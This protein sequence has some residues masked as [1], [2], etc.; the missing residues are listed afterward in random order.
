MSEKTR[1]MQLALA[2]CV[3]AAFATKDALGGDEERFDSPWNV[4]PERFNLRALTGGGAFGAALT[5]ATLVA[6]AVFC[7]S[8]FFR[9]GPHAFTMLHE[10]TLPIAI[11]NSIQMCIEFARRFVCNPADCR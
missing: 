2:A 1:L 4:P 3:A 8:A 6:I 7:V 9:S 11:C 10:Y 5:L